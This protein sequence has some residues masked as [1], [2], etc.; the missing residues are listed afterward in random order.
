MKER[1]QSSLSLAYGTTNEIIE[2]ETKRPTFTLFGSSRP[3]ELPHFSRFLPAARPSATTTDNPF[4]NLPN[5]LKLSVEIIRSALADNSNLGP[6]IQQ[7]VL[8]SIESIFSTS[9]SYRRYFSLTLSCSLVPTQHDTDSLFDDIQNKLFECLSRVELAPETRDRL[10]LAL[11][12]LSSFASLTSSLNCLSPL[13]VDL[14][15]QQNGDSSIFLRPARLLKLASV[16]TKFEGYG[17]VLRDSAKSQLWS[18]GNGQRH[19]HAGSAKQFVSQ[20]NLKCTDLTR[21]S[22]VLLCALQTTNC[23]ELSQ[24][25]P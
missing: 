20:L 12:N 25:V 10:V 24:G 15:T 3:S 6:F 9:A 8:P 11:L 16:S 7:I 4:A 5:A 21:L 17:P 14:C 19:G 23:S 2:V 1:V 13:F 22:S 18:W